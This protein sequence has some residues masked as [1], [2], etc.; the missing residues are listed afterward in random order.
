M[1]SASTQRCC[2][3]QGFRLTLKPTYHY[4]L[5]LLFIIIYL[6][7]SHVFV[8]NQFYQ[9]WSTHSSIHF[10]LLPRLPGRNSHLAVAAVAL[11]RSR[12]CDAAEEPQGSRSQ[13]SLPGEGIHGSLN[14]PI[15]H[16]PTKIG[17]WSMPWLLFSGDVQYSQN[18]TV[19]NPWNLRLQSWQ[20]ILDSP[21]N[22][23]SVLGIYTVHRGSSCVETWNPKNKTE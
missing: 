14:V 13:E 15:E 1:V 10:P 5:L 8:L 9:E 3:L 18:G 17:I 4:L 11:R 22:G 6:F 16:H 19:T 23:A 21:T 7:F 20:I 2:W 12:C